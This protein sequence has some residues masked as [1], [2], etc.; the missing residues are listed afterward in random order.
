MIVR[1]V[2]NLLG[3]LT[4]PAGARRQLLGVYDKRWVRPL[5]EVLQVLGSEHVLVVHSED[6]LDEISISASTHIAE[7]KDGAITE[8][9]VSP[10][11]FGLKTSPLS[12]LVIENSDH[13]L[14]LMRQAMAG[15]HE[16]SHEGAANI[17]ALNAGAAIYV[18]GQCHSLGAGVAMAQDA[19]GSGLA[20]EKMNDFVDFTVRLTDFQ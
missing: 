16:Q 1:T 17:V 7:L 4:N 14:A 5:A 10:G 8:Y 6:G 15:K 2:F 11:D 13:S 12:E 20:T 9:D 19:I 3:P 18:S